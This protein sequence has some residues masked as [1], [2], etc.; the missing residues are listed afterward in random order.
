MYA[1]KKLYLRISLGRGPK[2]PPHIAHTVR[3]RLG[4][5]L[6]GSY[7]PK[8]GLCSVVKANGQLTRDDLLILNLWLKHQFKLW[9]HNTGEECY[10]VPHP[11][12]DPAYAFLTT[13]SHWDGEYG[14]MRLNLAKHLLDAAT[15]DLG[16]KR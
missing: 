15:R 6:S 7:R 13:P 14:R 5:V 8:F 9:P 4:L 2:L 3:V 1:L 11:S 10:P 16:I 12:L